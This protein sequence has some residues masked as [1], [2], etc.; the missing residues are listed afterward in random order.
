MRMKPPVKPYRVLDIG[1]GEGKDAVFLAGNGYN[2]TAFDVSEKGLS[3]ARELA[4]SRSVAL[5]LFKAD[6]MDFRLEAEFDIIF[7]SGV[8]HYIPLRLRESV[9]ENLKSHTAENGINV[10][11]VFVRKPFIPPAPDKEKGEFAADRW[12]SGELFMYYHD[13]LL[14]KNDEMIFDCCSGGI[15]HKHC[16]DVV[17]AERI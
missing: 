15:P 7:S 4:E 13:W 5:N 3:K 6:I 16:M 17:I 10:I 12:K 1:C 8:F 11:N 14:H 9:I 2:V